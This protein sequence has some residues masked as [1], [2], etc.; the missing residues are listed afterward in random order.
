MNRI[1]YIYLTFL[2]FLILSGCEM[3]NGPVEIISL[4]ASDSIA[5]SGDLV[6]LVCEAQDSDKDKLSYEWQSSS[7]DISADRDTARWTAP[8]KS[9]YYHVT[10]KAADGVGA[11]DVASV[12]IRVV[13]GIIS[14]TVTNAVNG[15]VLEGVSVSIGESSV[16]TNDSGEYN[17]YLALQGGMYQVAA[18]ID[19]FCPY[20]GSFEIPEDHSSSLFTF[21]F[22]L[23]PFPEPGEI[24]MVLNWGSSPNDLDS[25][26]KTPEIEGQTHHISYS[27]RGSA[28]FAPFATLDVDDTDGYGPET[29]TIKQSFSGTYI[30]YIY[31]YSSSGSFQ[32]SGGSIQI[33]NSPTCDGETIQVPVDGSGRYWYVCDIDGESGDIT[34]INQIQNSE[35]TN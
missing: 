8:N 20:D 11:S 1:K 6:V 4:T 5:R 22:S 27:N 35:P 32:E 25:H 31:Q 29:I 3:K 18:L 10:C 28:D 7:G 14:G 24:R 30:Y 34:V 15:T 19:S 9:G 16:M 2:V 12:S 21:N 33:Y 26:L 17:F 23:S 13:G